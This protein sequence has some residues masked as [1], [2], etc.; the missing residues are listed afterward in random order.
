MKKRNE[1][2]EKYKWDLSSYFYSDQEWDSVF[3]Q[4]Q[5]QSK[6]FLQFKNKLSNREY[7]LEYYQF[8]DKF[9]E[10]MDKLGTY[11]F[12][13]VSEDAKNEISQKRE[14]IFSKFCAELGQKTS[15]IIV[16]LSKIDENKLTLWASQPE[17]KNYNLEILDIIKN[18]PH[19]LSQAEENLLAQIAEFEGGYSEI[20]EKLDN[21]DLRFENI[22]NS[23]G[24]SFAFNQALYGKYIQSTDRVLRKNAVKEIN[25]AYGKFN[26]TISA[27]YI[28]SVKTTCVNARIRKFESALSA[29][30]FS[31]NVNKTVYDALIMGVNQN[32]PVFQ[33]YFKLKAKQQ[34]NKKFAI[35]DTLSPTNQKFNKVYTYDQAFEIV[36]NALKPFGKNYINLLKQAKQEKWIDVMPSQ[37]KDTG[38]FST[39]AYGAK[40][41]VLLNFTGT[42]QDVFTLAH[43]LGHAMHTYFSNKTQLC[44]K[45]D[46]SIFVAEVASNV[47]EMLLGLYFLENSKTI[48]EKIYYI[49]NILS[50]FRGSVFR[51]TMFAEFEQKVHKKYESGEPLTAE[52]LNDMFY[53]LNKKYFG[54]NVEL[55]SQVKYEW[56]R[57][58][59][60][61]TPF[62]V[63]KYATGLIS[64]LILATNLL[65]ENK[66]KTSDNLQIKYL[67][68]LSSGCTKS[69]VELLQDAGVDLEKQ[70]TFNNAFKYIEN[71]IK[72]WESL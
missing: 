19:V 24:K 35:Y 17:F 34:G 59:H 5:E 64:A 28:Y 53:K 4:V 23:K 1:I 72:I 25:N 37:N 51:Q 33:K 29:S 32:L 15:F 31:T 57:I 61:Y 26:H 21:A 65:K 48:E 39:G 42:T 66:L 47:N 70:E 13:K 10:K 46:Y 18:R 16:E 71:L 11:S 14:Q 56:S 2:E 8:C 22:K 58:P 67:N 41:V 27:N 3:K 68:F 44:A 60:F 54:K 55:L 9:D 62:Y 6:Y 43:E 36:Q 30:L 20:F 40:P 50:G 63:Y 12:L 49:D 52:I 7:L 69:P 38:A 45:S